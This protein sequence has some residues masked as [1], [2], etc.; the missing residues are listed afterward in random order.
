MSKHPVESVIERA[1]AAIV[2]ED[3]DALMEFYADDAV[4]VVKP[5]TIA[6]GKAEIR[7]ASERIAAHFDHS[8]VVEQAGLRLLEAG[9]TVLVLAKTIIASAESP[10]V[11]R[12]ATYVFR[13]DLTGKWLC[14]IDNSYGHKLLEHPE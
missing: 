4:L 6:H 8:L 1:D 3:F 10:P 14:V 5:G 2:S 9:D 7:A 11:E 13:R 12:L